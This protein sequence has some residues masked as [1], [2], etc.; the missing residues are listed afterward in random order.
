MNRRSFATHPYHLV[1]ISPWPILMSFALLSGAL[2]LVSW[3]TLGE[4]SNLVYL[5]IL[6]NIVLIFILW[7]RDVIREGKAG[8]HTEAVASGIKLGFILFLVSEVMVFFSIFWTYLH[9]SLNP[10]VELV[11]WPPLG[12]NAVDY[13]SLPLLNS[14]LLLSGGFIA[15]WGHHA[16]LMGNKINAI[17]GLLIAIILTIFFQYLQYIEYN[18][19]EFTMS[20]SVYGSCFF[21]GTGLHGIHVKMAVIFQLVA[22]YRIYSD[23]VTSTHALILDFSLVYFHL[24]AVVWLALYQV[25]YFWGS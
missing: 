25:F 23:S 10:S 8:F 11:F 16:F 12:I 18:F 24:V 1:D 14:I 13:L 7:L 22:T 17:L 4:N 15:T 6:S 9:S 19:A 21:A 3:Q 5:I 2:A 20:D